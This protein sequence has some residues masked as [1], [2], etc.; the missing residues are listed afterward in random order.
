[1]PGDMCGLDDGRERD[2]KYSQHILSRDR[3][4]NNPVPLMRSRHL[5]VRREGAFVKG[6]RDC[7]GS[8]ALHLEGALE[9]DTP[10][11]ARNGQWNVK[12]FWDLATAM[13]Q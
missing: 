10:R 2:E 11:D 6:R 1:M 9:G 4:G 13:V 3:Q 12:Q 5:H 8:L 7:K